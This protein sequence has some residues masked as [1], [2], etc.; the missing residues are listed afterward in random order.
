MTL[1]FFLKLLLILCAWMFLSAYL[2]TMGSGGARGSQKKAWDPLELELQMAVS[3][4]A[5]EGKELGPLEEWP[6]LFPRVISPDPTIIFCPLLISWAGITGGCHH[7]LLCGAGNQIRVFICASQTVSLD[8][9]EWPQSC[10]P[11]CLCLLSDRITGE[12]HMAY[13]HTQ[14]L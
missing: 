7:S 13:T 2:Y 10:V 3:H 8:S 12:Y 5:G 4:H 9:L 11:F 6:V 1:N 14:L